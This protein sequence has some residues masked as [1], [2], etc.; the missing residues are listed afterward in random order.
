M[1]TREIAYTETNVGTDP[2]NPLCDLREED[3]A[4][5]YNEIIRSM[6]VFSRLAQRKC[7]VWTDVTARQPKGFSKGKHGPNSIFSILAG[8]LANYV[9][10]T[11]KYGVCRLSKKQIQDLETAF[12]LL[13]YVDDSFS[14]IRFKQSLFA[15]G[16]VKF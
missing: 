14:R 5:L 4:W 13:P 3:T 2:K 1:N 9:E 6:G 8:I 10:N 11:R 15:V 12:T 7:D 16:D